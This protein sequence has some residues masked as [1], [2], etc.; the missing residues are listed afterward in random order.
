MLRAAIADESVAMQHLD[1]AA[2]AAS[3]PAAAVRE[4]APGPRRVTAQARGAARRL[5]FHIDD[6]E[7]G[8]ARLPQGF[9]MHDA[10]TYDPIGQQAYY[11]VPNVHDGQITQVYSKNTMQRLLNQ[12]PTMSPY[13]RR[14]FGLDTIARVKQ[15]L[16]TRAASR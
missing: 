15:E 4:P 8:A 7:E 16:R 11:I 1:A 6:V 3:T 12:S 9:E 13:T 2:A 10:I 5:V 14:P